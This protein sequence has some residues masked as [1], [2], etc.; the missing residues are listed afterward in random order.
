MAVAHVP[1]LGGSIPQ[2][3]T[4][5]GGK[6]FGGRWLY[7]LFHPWII[8]EESVHQIKWAWQRLFRGWDDRVAYGIDWY[9]AKNMP[10]WIERMKEYG[11]SYPFDLTY[12]EWHGILD[13]M[14]VGFDAGY[15]LLNEDF[16]AWKELWDSCWEG[17]D[18]PNPDEFWPK[19]SEQKEEATKKFDRGMELFV[20]WFWN[21][22][23]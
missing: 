4:D 15:Q 5:S 1:R 6:M 21:M 20:K 23:D 2:T 3:P 22:W 16:P 8:I 19:L 10:A 7:L 14:S 9:I 18:V 17:G 11:N 12:E 13:E